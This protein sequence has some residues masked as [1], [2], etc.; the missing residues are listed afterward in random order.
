MVQQL[1]WQHKYVLTWHL[2][3]QASKDLC[4]LLAQF[5]SPTLQGFVIQTTVGLKQHSLWRSR[6]VTFICTYK[7]KIQLTANHVFWQNSILIC[8]KCM[9]GVNEI[10]QSIFYMPSSMKFYTI[11]GSCWP[12]AVSK[13][14]VTDITIG[15]RVEI[16][17]STFYLD[18]HML[19]QIN[20]LKEKHG[21]DMTS[22]YWVS[23]PTFLR[24]KGI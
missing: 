20:I 12:S 19:S 9:S 10:F 16:L 4:P 1:L 23:G 22:C 7:H 13:R 21:C 2:K 3:H 6:S 24:D 15:I 8:T 14:S 5:K 18:M 17:W 11:Y